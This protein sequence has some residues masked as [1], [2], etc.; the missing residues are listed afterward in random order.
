MRIQPT[1]RLLYSATPPVS[2][3]LLSDIRPSRATLR[4]EPTVVA[5]ILQLARLRS[6]QLSRAALILPSVM[7]LFTTPQVA[8][9]SR[10]AIWPESTSPPAAATSSLVTAAL[11]TTLPQSASAGQLRQSA[12]IA[13]IRGVTTG[14]GDAIPVVIDSASQLGTVSSSKR[15]KKEIKPMDNASEAI[16]GLKPVT[17]PVQDR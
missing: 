12:Y 11:R 6:V 4:R 13:G 2:K 3:I 16:L 17:F 8:A 14:V 10:S 15:F 1:E 9:I 5:P 7:P